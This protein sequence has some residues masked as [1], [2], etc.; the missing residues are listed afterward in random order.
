M[1]GVE[2]E[3]RGEAFLDI[4]QDNFLCPHVTL[5]TR[6][7]NILDLVISSEEKL[8]SNLMIGPS[9]GGVDHSSIDFILNLEL[10]GRE[11]PNLELDYRKADY[12]AISKE[13]GILI[14]IEGSVLC[15]W[16]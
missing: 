5:A 1:G 6:E 13:L 16:N 7:A 8:V 12:A 2:Q 3:W 4:V 15:I 10:P 14:G 9:I 11:Q